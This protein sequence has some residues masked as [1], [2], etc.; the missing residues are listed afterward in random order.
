MYE[1]PI[2][3]LVKKTG[4]LYKLVIV[5]ARRSIELSEGA[6]RLVDVPHD[7]KA[8]SIALKEILEDRVTYKLKDEK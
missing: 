4:S 7:A 1:T 6:T 2:D 3:E 5:A 8:A